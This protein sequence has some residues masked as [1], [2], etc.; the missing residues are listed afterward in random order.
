M[1]R[2]GIELLGISSYSTDVSCQIAKI[3]ALLKLDSVY[4]EHV[5]NALT[6]KYGTLSTQLDKIIHNANG[7]IS[8]LRARMTS[9]ITCFCA[10]TCSH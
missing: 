1:C 5:A 4:Q 3:I 2:A 10:I 9:N 6:G 8:N 7:E